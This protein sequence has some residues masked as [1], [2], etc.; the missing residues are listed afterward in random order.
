M[1]DR[2]IQQ[3]IHVSEGCKAVTCIVPL[4]HLSAMPHVRVFLEG[5]V[6]VATDQDLTGEDFRV[7]LVCLSEME[8]E[9]FLN[10]TQSELAEIL[11]IRQQAVARSIKKLMS[12][13][14][15]K[16]V[17]HRGRQNIYQINPYIAFKS[18]AKNLEVML[19]AW[20][21]SIGIVPIDLE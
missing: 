3:H 2:I 10:R 6:N 15:I 19:D 20:E 18:R 17:G 8:F 16:I 21:S 11:G 1:P 7:L 13:G 14:Y 9:N 5:L 4:K 12:K